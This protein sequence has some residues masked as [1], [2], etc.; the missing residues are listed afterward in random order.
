MD[1]ASN[2]Y[3]AYVQILKEELLP[4]M[5]C[6]EPIALA[7]AAAVARKALGQMPDKVV[8]AASGSI[9]KNVKSVIVPNT[10][11]LKGIPAAVAAGI[12]AGNPERELEVIAE[13]LPEQIIQMREFMKEREITVVHLDQGINF[14]I[15]V[16]LYKG[17]SFSRVRIAGYHTN[18]VLIEKD[19]TIL[20][21]KDAALEDDP[22]T[23]RNLLNME[24]IWD[25]INSV[26]ISDIQE[27]LERQIRYNWA[28][29]EE[30]LKESYGANIG[31]VLLKNSGDDLSVRAKAMAA[32]GSDARMNGCGLP[33]VIN[34]GS[35]NQGITVSVP[36]IV[37]AKALKVSKEKLYR[38]LALSN[39]AAIHQKTPIGRLS[40]YCGAVNAGAGAGAGIAY[41]CGGGYEEV[42][43]TIVNALAIVSGIVCDG[44]KSSCAAKIASSI[45]AGILGYN[46]Y[47]QGQQFFD[48]DGIVTKGVE[49][50]L[51]NVGRLGKE[52]MRETNEEI[53]RIMIGE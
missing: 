31:K 14:D 32:A 29:A 27:V 16:T 2:K 30:G 48:G 36:V 38:A 42:I 50:T 52:G 53:I 8:V 46:M 22:L 28:I 4:A 17:T 1:K 33:V 47:M 45:E 39:L 41:L 13:V 19:G 21:Q 15:L 12:V 23:D 24:D 34:S 6:T 3:R 35:G 49:A 5:G 26:D 44:A 40:A 7:Y 25:F 51:R 10:G 37:Y 43:H 11:H 9:I 18:I 20:M